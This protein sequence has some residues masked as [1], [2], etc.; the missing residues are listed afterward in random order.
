MPA[1]EP[2]EVTV[3]T[4]DKELTAGTLWIHERGGQTASFR[5]ADSYLTAP[6][7]YSLDPVLPVEAG[8]FH[9]PPGLAMFSA[10][11]DSA[12][13][14]WGENL[15]R[16]A[17]RERAAAM[18]A[19]PRTLAKADFLLG[20]RDDTRE[21]SVRF[22][23]A[24]SHSYYSAHRN[25]VPRLIEVARLLRAAERLAAE[26]GFDRDI[27]DLIDAG[28]SLGGARPKA[29][30]IN[31]SGRLTIAKFPRSGSDEWDAPAWEETEL[32]LARR[33]GITVPGSALLPIAGRHVLLV[34]RFDRRRGRRIGFASALTML[35][36]RDGEQ[37]SYLEIGEVIERYSPQA[38]ADL[39]ELFRRIIFSIL[40]A[41][42]DDHLRNHAFLREGGGWLLSPAYDL[43]PNPDNPGRLSTTI[44][45]DDADASIETALSVAGYFR[46]SAAEARSIV[47]DVE[48]ATADWQR[49]ATDLGLPGSQIS[50]MADAYETEQRR[51]ARLLGS[52]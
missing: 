47:A 44:D 16:R 34:E 30:V 9:T 11:A 7:S 21:G 5:Y 31:A 48:R 26:G 35:E 20:V 50:R 52:A 49:V 27:A 40:T 10:F 43:N 36:A 51:V 14:R 6:G 39:R 32:R 45:V 38:E 28:S 12:P 24:G 17:E 13:D 37:R 19:T 23:Q 18:A 22:R 42:T 46:L 2:V 8:V 4:G 25:A 3:E 1:R 41:N 33:A 15:M 29:T